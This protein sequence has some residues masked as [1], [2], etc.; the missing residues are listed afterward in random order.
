MRDDEYQEDVAAE[1]TSVSI[2]TLL[3]RR[4][5]LV[6]KAE[7]LQSWIDKVS[8]SA[9]PISRHLPNL[10]GFPIYLPNSR[11]LPNPC[12]FP[13][14][15]P[16]LPSQCACSTP[17]SKML[18]GVEDGDDAE[19]SDDDDDDDDDGEE[20]DEEALGSQASSLYQQ[21]KAALLLQNQAITSLQEAINSKLQSQ[22]S[23]LRDRNQRQHT[24]RM[25]LAADKVAEVENEVANLVSQS[26]TLKPSLEQRIDKLKLEIDALLELQQVSPLTEEQELE[27]VG[28]RTTY[29]GLLKKKKKRKRGEM[30][31]GT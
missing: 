26:A 2:T 5:H 11:H 10:C 6:V 16:N 22:L 15:L 27:L 20:D 19:I 13:I 23:G 21:N 9:F 25:K 7:S 29:N 14:Y 12:G 31:A 3:V 28:K 1:D 17:D 4:F 30:G 24:E 18:N 8:L